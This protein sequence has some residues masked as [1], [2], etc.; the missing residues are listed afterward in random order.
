MAERQKHG[1]DYENLKM[2]ENNLVKQENYTSKWDTY[3]VYNGA[4]TGVSIKCIGLNSSIDFG[5]FIRQTQVDEDFILYVGFWSGSKNKIVE[6]Y[7]VLIKADVWKGYFGDKTITGQMIE[8][9]KGIS[10]LYSDDAKWKDFRNKYKQ[11]YGKSIIS[12]RFKR[13]H[14][15]QKRIQCGITKQNFVNFVLSDNVI[16]SKVLKNS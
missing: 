4:Q 12:L 5:D 15:K 1:F 10:N 11:M 9:M 2:L 14:K 7:K 13:D 3:E 16:L 6:E 8:E